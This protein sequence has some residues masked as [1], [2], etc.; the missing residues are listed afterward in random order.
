MNRTKVKVHGFDQPIE[1]WLAESRR[2]GSSRPAL[3]ALPHDEDPK[4]WPPWGCRAIGLLPKAHREDK[5]SSLAV[6]GI[7]VG[8]DKVAVEGTRIAVLDKEYMKTT[9]PITE[10][11]VCTTVRTKDDSFPLLDA[12]NPSDDD[13][14][15]FVKSVLPAE[16]AGTVP[17]AAASPPEPPPRSATP[18]ATKAAEQEVDKA[19]EEI[20]SAPSAREVAADASRAA[21]RVI[22]ARLAS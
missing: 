5:L 21:D 1:P 20:F 10:V 16:T 14:E 3:A 7:F 9:D 4:H 2:S 15:E 13:L 22:E 11:I 17:A 6:A 12:V 8:M 19:M 18:E